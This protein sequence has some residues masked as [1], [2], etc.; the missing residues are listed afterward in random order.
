[1]K[2]VPAL[3]IAIL[4]AG[5]SHDSDSLMGRGADTE[6]CYPLQLGNLWE[7]DREFRS[8]NYRT[9]GGD[10]VA[11]DTTV[12]RSHSTVEIVRV[13][14]LV[15]LTNAFVLSEIAVGSDNSIFTGE[16]YYF[17]HTD[18][19][20]L[21][22]HKGFTSAAPKVPSQ[23]RI[24][25]KGFY[26]NSAREVI[27]FIE[28]RAFS[29]APFDSLIYEKK[30][31]KVYPYPIWIDLQWNYRPANDPWRVDKRVTGKQSVSVPAGEFECYRIQWLIDLDDD[32]EWDED[33]EFF[34]YVS[35]SGLT[36]QTLLV[37]D[38]MWTDAGGWPLGMFDAMDEYKLTNVVLK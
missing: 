6:F 14:A 20:Y 29:S 22:A 37:R 7:Y 28:R 32:G 19:L 15:P 26:F 13:D 27:N 12:Y 17:N 4:L 2:S 21:Y 33:I 24:L 31:L 5:C 1:M 23:R 34:D 38:M 35:S 3:T 10:T 25:F 11:G 30:P 36:Q 18:G 9:P 16:A 8:L